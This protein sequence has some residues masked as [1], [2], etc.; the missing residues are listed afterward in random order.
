MNHTQQCRFLGASFWKGTKIY[1]K[2]KSISVKQIRDYTSR[3]KTHK[4]FLEIGN[5]I[6]ESKKKK[7]DLV[8]VADKQ[9]K[10]NSQ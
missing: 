8:I 9:F 5:Y 3:N 7:K 6:L 4:D 10:R 1:K 2:K